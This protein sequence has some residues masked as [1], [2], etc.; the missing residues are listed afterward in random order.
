MVSLSDSPFE[1]LDDEADEKPITLAP[2]L[3][4]ALSKLNL[5]RV[6]GSKNKVATTKSSRILW[7]GFFSNSSEISKIR[8]CCS[9][10]K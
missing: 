7:V 8:S 1:T 10:V 4:A 5:V 3:E 2:S 9:F 6:E